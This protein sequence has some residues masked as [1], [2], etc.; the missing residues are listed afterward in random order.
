MLI[1]TLFF[2]L[3]SPGIL[4]TIPPVHEQIFMSNKTSF[5]AV[6]VHAIIFA[7]VLYFK[8]YIPI[9]KSLEGFQDAEGSGE[10]RGAT[11]ESRAA[12]IKAAANKR[13]ETAKKIVSP[14]P[15]AP[16]DDRI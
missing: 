10:A 15:I 9:V 3:L 6:I 16:D 2:I 5:L 13:R 7:A 11:A 14:I 1:E 4:L 8:R 12:V